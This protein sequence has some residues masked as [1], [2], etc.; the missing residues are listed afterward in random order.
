MKVQ[1]ISEF[2]LRVIFYCLYFVL[3]GK[4]QDELVTMLSKEADFLE[5]RPMLQEALEA[6]GCH[7]LFGVKF[8]P[9]LMMIESCYRLDLSIY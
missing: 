4:R 5:A 3:L 7:V 2:S 8:H 9:E 1:S 6:I